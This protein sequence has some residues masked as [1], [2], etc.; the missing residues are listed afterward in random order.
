VNSD[1]TERSRSEDRDDSPELER[2][3]ALLVDTH[4]RIQ[5]GEDP[6]KAKAVAH[7]LLDPGGD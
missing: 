7:E 6:E 4:E 5:S 3:R 2:L 1:E